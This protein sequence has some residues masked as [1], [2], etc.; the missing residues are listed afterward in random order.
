MDRWVLRIEKAA[1]LSL[2]AVA[3]ITFVSV[4]LRGTVGFAIPDGFDISRLLLAV[5]MFWGIASTGYRNEHIQV[6]VLW[7]AFSPEGRRRLDLVATGV[8]LAFMAVFSAMLAQKVLSGW[9]SGEATFD[10]RIEIWPFHL[11]AALGIA[12][13]TLL[14]AIRLVRLYRRE[15]L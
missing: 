13:A 12:C 3:L 5:A 15:P 7:Q 10:I 9:R 14:L 11:A 1:G 6:D 2:A 8:S 4:S